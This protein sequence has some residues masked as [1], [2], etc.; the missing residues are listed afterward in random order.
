MSQWFFSS[1]FDSFL[2]RGEHLHSSWKIPWV[3]IPKNQTLKTEGSELIKYKMWGPTSSVSIMICHVSCISSY[4]LE[5]T[6]ANSSQIVWFHYVRI[7]DLNPNSGQQ[8]DFPQ[9]Q[10]FILLTWVIPS[11]TIVVRCNNISQEPTVPVTVNLI[12][13]TSTSSAADSCWPR[14]YQ[15]HL[16][17]LPMLLLGV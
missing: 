15:H 14:L 5:F 2:F 12:S 6:S 17:S 8:V 16:L 10:V 13:T 11:S 7:S 3:T 1:L 9:G 4:L